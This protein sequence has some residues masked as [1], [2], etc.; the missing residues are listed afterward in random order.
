MADTMTRQARLKAVRCLLEYAAAEAQELGLPQLEQLL[1]AASVN[2]DD[3]LKPKRRG[4]SSAEGRQPQL[5]L[6]SSTDADCTKGTG[7]K[8]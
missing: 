2:V 8:T 4:P 7:T 1:E 6:I 3:A 5:R